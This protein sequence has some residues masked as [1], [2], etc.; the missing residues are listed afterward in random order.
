MLGSLNQILMLSPEGHARSDASVMV[1]CIMCG[2]A[3]H[4]VRR[5]HRQRYWRQA[6][7]LKRLLSVGET[8]SQM[9]R[10]Q[11]IVKHNAHPRRR[12]IKCAKDKM[13]M[14]SI[15]QIKTI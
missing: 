7:S 1:R 14:F 10:I 12:E 4:G 9:V 13:A 5:D 11:F 6:D 15:L 2:C 8:V 3:L